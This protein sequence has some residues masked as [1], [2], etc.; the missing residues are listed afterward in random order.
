MLFSAGLNGFPANMPALPT[1][2]VNAGT[3]QEVL[4]YLNKVK[5]YEALNDGAVWRKR[6]LHLSGGRSSEELP[7]FRRFVEAYKQT[8][9]QQILGARVQLLS[10]QTDEPTEALNAQTPVN[11]GVGLLTFFG[12]SS[13]STSDLDIGLVSNEVLGYRNKGKYP[14]LLI[15]GCAMGN[16]FFGLPTLATDWIVTP[17]RGAIAALAHSHLG[18]IASLHN[19]ATAFYSVITDSTQISKSVGEWQQETIRRALLVWSG[20]ID[21]A[22]A[23]QMVLQGD[24][25]IRIFP[26]TKP[27]Y[28]LS[29]EQFWVKPASQ[30]DSIRLGLVVSNTGLFRNDPLTV[31]IQRWYGSNQYSVNNKIMAQATAYQDTL[32][33][34]LPKGVIASEKQT[35][36][37]TVNP[38]HSIT[39]S[40]YTNN[41]VTVEVNLQ[42]LDSVIAI[43]PDRVPPLVE[44]AIDGQFIQ[45]Q[46]VVSTQP[47]LTIQVIDD[48][49]LLLRRDTVGLD[50][51]LQGPGEMSPFRRLPWKALGVQTSANLD[52]TIFQ[53]TYPLPRLAPG[54]YSLNM[55]AQ[56]LSGNRAAPYQIRFTVVDNR[57]LTDVTVYPNPFS[58]YQT[59]AFTLTGDLPPD[60]AYIQITDLTGHLICHIR[61]SAR[62]GLNQWG[63]DGRTDNGDL[64]S[65]GV[66]T[67]R[68]SLKANGSDWPATDAAHRQQ[69]G[70]ILL[71]R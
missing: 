41:Q 29:S 14:F 5:E 1:G 31:R 9:E 64:L 42:Q 57:Q 43:S 8:A 38:E 66:Y 67:Y 59:I 30:S 25:A 20:P 71:I 34:T 48:N 62:I 40:N 61:Q 47:T 24:P 35:L 7:L 19:Y 45:N 36:I 33:V 32:W 46:A 68:L 28:S 70:L 17:D 11:E 23:Q 26:F 50:L 16:F 27:D 56:D 69:Q 39:E 54:T 49:R 6:L 22:N 65:N 13:L 15:N 12:H 53:V 58:H 10:K 3:P 18:Y 2:R 44:V 63:W 60:E 51:Y 52:N 4:N 37:A 55:Q 21:L